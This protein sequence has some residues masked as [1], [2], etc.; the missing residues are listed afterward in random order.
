[1]HHMATLYAP[2]CCA[3][4]LLSLTGNVL[5]ALAD[6]YTCHMCMLLTCYVGVTALQTSMMLFDTFVAQLGAGWLC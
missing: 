4:T 3:L 5:C 1:M 2:T 6:R